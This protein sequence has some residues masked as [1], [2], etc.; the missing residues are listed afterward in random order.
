MEKIQPHKWLN[1]GISDILLFACI[2]FTFVFNL[3]PA[4]VL[5]LPLYTWTNLFLFAFITYMF[6]G[7]IFRGGKIRWSKFFV[8]PLLFIVMG[9]ISI[10]YSFAVLDSADRCRRMVLLFFLMVAVY[11]YASRSQE[12]LL[13]ALKMFMWGGVFAAVY[14][15]GFSDLHVAQRVG[16]VIGDSNLIGMIMAFASVVALFLWHKLREK[17]YLVAWAVLAAAVLLTG[18]RSSFGLLLVGLLMTTYLLNYLQKK[19]VLKLFLITLAVAGLLVG[20]VYIVMNVQ[21]LYDILGIRL[22]SFYQITHGMTSVNNEGSTQ[23]R[24]MFM[25]KAWNWFLHSP[26]WLGHGINSFPAYNQQMIYGG[27]YS[28]SH[29]D[30]VELLSGV[31]VPG[32]V[33]FFAPYVLWLRYF[34]QAAKKADVFFCVLGLTLTTDF[35]LGEWFLCMYYE[36]STW[37]MFA[38]LTAVYRLVKGEVNEKSTSGVL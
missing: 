8:W 13:R 25:G 18:S 2:S 22:Q 1:F 9:I 11:Q 14:L 32:F 7:C 6:A 12:Y 10:S 29:C 33:F 17:M 20:M 28:F 16:E 27:W 15:M 19:N 23:L 30:Y 37:I 31:G 35:L 3:N 21:F 38:L 26:F 24:L 5:G 34:W 36:K 4:R